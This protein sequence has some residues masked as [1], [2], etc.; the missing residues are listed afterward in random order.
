MP[1]E[2]SKQMHWPEGQIPRRLRRKA[3]SRACP[4]VHA[5]DSRLVSDRSAGEPHRGCVFNIQRYTVHDGPGIRTEIFLKGCTQHCLWCS[6]PES[7]RAAPEVGLRPNRCLG[8]DKCGLCLEACPREALVFSGGVVAGIDRAVCSACRACVEACPAEAIITWGAWMSL[9]EVMQVIR[10]DVPFYE[11]SGGGVTVSGGEPLLQWRFTRELL[12]L[13]RR[14]RLHTC[15][16]TA[17]H[18]QPRILEEVA[19]QADL[20]ICDIKHMDPERHRHCTGVGNERILENI[21][22]TARSGKPM[23]IRVP[24]IPGYNDDEA[25]LVATARFVAAEL[26]A[27]V[28]QVQL[29]RYRKLG[30]EKYASLG[31]DYPLAELE[32]P[33]VGQAEQRI[34]ELAQLMRAEG[35]PA[36]AG[37]TTAYQ[38]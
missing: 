26:N 32:T 15:L 20:I 9:E 18:V 7:L 22:S 8:S 34:R 21:R 23:V 11:R 14:E 30:V 33:A 4:G 28:R 29:L 17:M 13:C 19:P 1:D 35:V 3:G 16:E 25:N 37:T 36:V 27:C 12:R 10:R 38:A 2:R 6:N 5:H 24:V 31:L